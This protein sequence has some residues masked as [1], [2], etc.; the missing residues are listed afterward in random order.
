MTTCV[1]NDYTLSYN[2][3]AKMN[4]KKVTLQ[5]E[6]KGDTELFFSIEKLN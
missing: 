2:Y 3:G 1:I 5:S 6:I 4:S